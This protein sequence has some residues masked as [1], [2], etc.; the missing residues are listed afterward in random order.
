MPPDSAAA[1]V[2]VGEAIVPCGPDA[3]FLA[4]RAVSLWLEGHACARLY[5]D[6]GLR[7]GLLILPV[8]TLVAAAGL[9]LHRSRS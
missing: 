7:A 4:R 8:L 2:K 1:P 3:P 9:F 6:A 5:H